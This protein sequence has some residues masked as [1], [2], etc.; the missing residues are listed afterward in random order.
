VHR[1]AE[2]ERRIRLAYL[3]GAQ[4]WSR[5]TVGRGLTE[6]ELEGFLRRFG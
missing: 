1:D 6:G 2:R 3:E 5:E 4:S